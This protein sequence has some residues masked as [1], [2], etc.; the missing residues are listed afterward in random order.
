MNWWDRLM[1][2]CSHH[3]THR[4]EL[5]DRVAEV[6]E[7]LDRVEEQAERNAREMS[8]VAAS[9]GIQD[10]RWWRRHRHDTG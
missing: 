2:K 7:R 8:A 4:E 1:P 6:E 3:D 9:V 10:L 5:D